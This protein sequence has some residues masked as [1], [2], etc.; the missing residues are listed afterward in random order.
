VSPYGVADL[1]DEQW[2][3]GFSEKPVLPYWINAGVYLIER[4]VGD[5]L[6]DLGDHEDSTFPQLAR[7]GR[8]LGYKATSYWRAVDSVKDMT[9]ATRDLPLQFPASLLP[10]R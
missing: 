7:E 6:P 9:E 10:E 3:Q 4:S 5:L 1:K 8:L 2:I